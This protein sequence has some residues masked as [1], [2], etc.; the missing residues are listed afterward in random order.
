ML[1]EKLKGC[2]QK[3]H[4]ALISL[5]I[6]LMVVARF[7]GLEDSPPGFYI[8]ESAAAS[9]ILCLSETGKD[10]TG[11]KFPF[12]YSAGTAGLNTFPYVYSGAVW[13]KVFGGSPY[14][15]RAMSAF[16]TI[17]TIVGIYFLA[18]LLSTSETAGYAVLSASIMPWSFHFSRIAWDPPMAPLFL[19]WG[20][21]FVL[22]S[23]R[24]FDLVLSGVLFSL[25][26]YSYSP[27]RVTVPIILL[28]ILFIK[29][30][31]QLANFKDS[32]WFLVP[33]FLSTAPLVWNVLYSPEYMARFH[34][35]N[36]ASEW[37][38]RKHGEP[39]LSLLLTRLVIEFFSHF[40]P[41]YLFIHGDKIERHSVQKFGEL[42][43]LDFL[44]ILAL[45]GLLIS[46]M[47]RSGLKV[48]RD[49][50]I[51]VLISVVTILA[52][53]LPSAITGPWPHALH[54]IT[55]WPFFAL[56]VGFGIAWASPRI[57]VFK[58]GIGLVALCFSLFYLHAVFV[59]YP[60]FAGP[61]FDQ[62]DKQLAVQAAT[63]GNWREFED[64]SKNMF[65]LTK[66]YYLM[67]YGHRACD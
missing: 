15:L 14:S 24:K 55:A 51:L 43:W 5:V 54:S 32:L 16:F 44:G 41:L 1:W 66:K 49:V 27:V 34:E 35:G 46:K 58:Y 23:N 65:Y 7:I 45:G 21:Y 2:S 40:D 10:A 57:G 11:K 30:R 53:I 42:S 20:V 64:N 60:L 47:A 50:P 17:F 29:K 37:N 62:A 67:Q 12:V 38:L 26:M 8:D 22:R 33:L 36:I 13:V 4:I 63:T 39:S 25:A 61:F 31:Q 19:V 28:A 59:K 18:R 3:T 56:L 48:F 52:S 6:A 9:H